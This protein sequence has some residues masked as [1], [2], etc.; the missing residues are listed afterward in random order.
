V[1]FTPGSVDVTR[2]VIDFPTDQLLG[3]A[4]YSGRMDMI[5][6]FGGLLPVIIIAKPHSVPQK[7]FINRQ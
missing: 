6:D 1:V 3:K 5:A 2:K 4:I 7:R